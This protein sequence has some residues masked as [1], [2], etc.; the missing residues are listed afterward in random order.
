[1]AGAQA[2]IHFVSKTDEQRRD[3][4]R[5][6]ISGT[7]N[8]EIPSTRREVKKNKLPIIHTTLENGKLHSI[9][10][11]NP[12]NFNTSVNRHWVTD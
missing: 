6:T 9:T 2:R 4:K 12:D 7:G 5:Y 10:A 1:M 11:L 3:K 8:Q